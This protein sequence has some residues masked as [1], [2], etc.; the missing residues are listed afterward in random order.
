MNQRQ[1]L[2]FRLLFSLM[3][4]AAICLTA[5]TVSA[6]SPKITLTYSFERP[7]IT[8]TTHGGQLYDRV[9][10]KDAP[11][12]GNV[13]QP[14]LPATGARVLIPYGHE[15]TSI[16]VTASDRVVL[17][18]GYMIEPVEPQ[19]KLGAKDQPILHAEPDPV[20]YLADRTFP[21]ATYREV[22]TYGFRGYRILIVR[23]QPVDF[24]PVTG[25]VAYYPEL[26]LNVT[27]TQTGMSSDLYRGFNED[28]MAVREKIDNPGTL[29]SYQAAPKNGSRAFDMLIITT[30]ALVTQFEPLRDYHNANGLAT[31]IHT[32]TDVGSTD[33][34]VVRGYIQSRYIFDGISY[35]IIGA[36]DDVIPA[37][38]LYVTMQEDG[39]E[40][41]YAMPGDL[42]FACLDGTWNY[43]GDSYWGENTDGPGGGDVDLIAEVYIGRASVNNSNEAYRFVNKT[44]QYI[45]S[46]GQYLQNV[47]MVG[48]Y[49]GFG[50]PAEYGGGY[51]DEI[52]DGSDAHGY[53]TVGIPTTLFNVETLYERDENWVQADL[54]AYVNDGL[55]ILN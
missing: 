44:L 9:V 4:V 35:V 43:D 6:A 22:A 42:Y 14:A 31:E 34:D 45:G 12:C 2:P 30:P 24:N 41:E 1:R 7:E 47:L 36:D 3:L 16:E 39:G 49:L 52:P 15:V 50:G 55:H 54:T 13:G 10:M 37:K 8:T 27:T 21:E 46:S 19:G 17:G 48:E 29:D 51:L 32:T 5:A 25:E 11:N 28:E 40:A 20:I 26:T 33:P 53:T 18:A 23:L 38:D